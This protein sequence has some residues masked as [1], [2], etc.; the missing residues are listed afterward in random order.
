M[1]QTCFT[2]IV[3]SAF[4]RTISAYTHAVVSMQKNV[5]DSVI[6]ANTTLPDANS[7]IK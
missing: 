3:F 1:M 5:S 4:I 2:F 7:D 6:S